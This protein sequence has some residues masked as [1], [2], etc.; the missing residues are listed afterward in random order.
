M[1]EVA[2]CGSCEG[3]TFEVRWG[4][5]ICAK[6]KREFVFADDTLAVDLVD[7]VNCAGKPGFEAV[8]DDVMTG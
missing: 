4:R 7:M 2:T 1:E 6:C 8:A 3:Q 5:I